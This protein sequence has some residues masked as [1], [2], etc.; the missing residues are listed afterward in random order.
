MEPRAGPPA[1]LDAIY[2]GTVTVIGSAT[3]GGSLAFADGSKTNTLYLPGFFMSNHS[4]SGRTAPI[5]SPIPDCPSAYHC[6]GHSARRPRDGA[7][8]SHRFSRFRVH[9]HAVVQGVTARQAHTSHWLLDV[10]ESRRQLSGRRLQRRT[11][12]PPGNRN[13]RF[14]RYGRRAGPKDGRLARADAGRGLSARNLGFALVV[15]LRR[16]HARVGDPK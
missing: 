1:R 8:S 10:K 6:A 15:G 4:A 11:E 5:A 12:T 16:R 9:Q 3:H 13:Q 14:P 2:F 7:N